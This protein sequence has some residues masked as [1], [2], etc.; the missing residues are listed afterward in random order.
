[1]NIDFTD[2]QDVPVDGA[3]LRRLAELVLT[4]EGLPAD[5][6]VSIVL[7]ADDVIAAY[8]RRF[9]HREGPTDVLAFPVERLTPGTVPRRPV[10]GPPVVL[11]DV[12]IAPGYVAAQAERLGTDVRTEMALMV[13]HGLLHLL[14][15]DHTA[16]A[17][18]ELMERRE[19]ELL[20][21]VGLVRR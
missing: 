19:R 5:T 8:N 18:A 4:S 21:E 9:L 1:M 6:E 7:V 20:A 15:Y 3:E 10:N 16:E 11:G 2:E 17:D 14:G 13:V 12:F